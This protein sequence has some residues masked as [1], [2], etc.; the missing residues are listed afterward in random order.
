MTYFVGSQKDNDNSILW[1]NFIYT[2]NSL[3]YSQRALQ[4]QQK[5]KT[6]KNK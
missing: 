1:F 2:E 4:S 6:F 5:N 3:G